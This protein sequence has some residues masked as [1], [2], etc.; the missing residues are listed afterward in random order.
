LAAA[1][2][3]TLPTALGAH[4]SRAWNAAPYALD[5]VPVVL[6]SQRN[7]CG[8][9]VVATLAAWSGRRLELASVVASAPLGPDGLSLGEFA[10]LADRFGFPG[11]WYRIGPGD[12]AGLPT[13]FVAHMTVAGSAPLGHLVAVRAVTRGAVTVADPAVGAYVLPLDAFT[14][15]FSGRVFLLEAL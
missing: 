2:V 4:A 8:P 1:A 11:T 15:R 6:Q 9:A 12:L 5:S 13:P 3:L 14:R 10:R 7:D